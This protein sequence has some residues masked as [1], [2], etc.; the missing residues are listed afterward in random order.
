MQLPGMPG[1]MEDPT[2]RE[3]AEEESERL[4][5]ELEKEVQTEIKDIGTL[6][7]E[8]RITVPAKIISEH[9]DYNYKELMH[10]ALVPGFRKGRAP[11]QLI[12]KRFGSEV[13]E[14]LTTSIVGQS[15]LA[16]TKNNELDVLGDPLFRMDSGAGDE[17][18]KLVDFDE[19]L[20]QLKLPAEGDF[21]Y[22]CE[23]EVKPTFELPELKGIEIKKP[24]IDITDEMLDDELLRQRK[25]RGRYEPQLEGAAEK[26]DMIVADVTL[27]VDDQTIKTEENVQLNVRPTAVDGI[28][29]ST[30]DEVLGGA[31]VGETR[32]VECT[33]PEDYERADLRGKSGRFEFK[34]HEL[35][36]L[37]PMPLDEYLERMGMEKESEA[38]DYYRTLME[39]ERDDMIERA[40]K[41]QIHT[42]LLD[43]TELDLPEK[44][45]NRQTERA[46]TRKIVDLRQ[47][48]VPESD[49]EAHIDE[50]RTSAKEDATRNLKLDFIL[51]KVAEELDIQVTDEEINS[52]I[53]RI[54]RLY[55]RRFDRIRDDLQKQNMLERLAEQFRHDKCVRR[56]LEDV[57]LIE[58]KAEDTKAADKKSKK[59]KT[60]KK[61]TKKTQD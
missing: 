26:D 33:I 60:K 7:R 18:V 41:D 6:R 40:K 24:K 44:L 55:N 23:V 54:A 31:K 43:N 37:A 48:G 14:S 13:R 32:P 22:I 35:K 58:V 8:L 15:F 49:I 34:I 27:L 19:A 9:M 53:A 4:L 30:L 25:I 38:R 50:L 2:L 51:G 59:K 29:I 56:L 45:S 47:R 3:K 10:D 16:A 28:E 5:E 1:A 17:G 42:Y 57:K 52:E 36:R 12:E 21:S 39:N 46:I 61:A 20:H 11:R